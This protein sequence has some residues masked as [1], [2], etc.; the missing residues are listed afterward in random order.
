MHVSSNWDEGLTW[1][2]SAGRTYVRDKDELR[3]WLGDRAQAGRMVPKGFPRGGR[4]S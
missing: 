2:D 1:Q 4:F 3:E